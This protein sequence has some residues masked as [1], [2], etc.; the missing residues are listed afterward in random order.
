MMLEENVPDQGGKYM[1]LVNKKGVDVSSCN[2][3]YDGGSYVDFGSLK[4]NDFNFIMIRCGYGSDLVTQDD[5]CFEENVKK[6]EEAGVPWGVYLYSYAL[7]AEQAKSEAEHVKRLLKG[8]KPTLPI[9]LDVEDADGYHERNGGWNLKTINTVVKTFIN[10]IRDAGYY[11]MLYCGFEEIENL[12]SE[13]VW[14]NVDIWWAQWW[15]EC[16]YK[17]DNLGMWQ[18]GGETNYRQS[19]YID[20]KI[21]DQDLCYKDY[22]TIIKQG[23]WNNWGTPTPTPSPKKKPIEMLAFEVL[24]G[25]WGS[26][27]ERKKLLTEAGYDYQ[28]VQNRVNEIC[29]SWS[30]PTL[31]KTGYKL[32]ESNIAILA[33]KEMINFARKLGIIDQGVSDNKVYGDGTLI[34]VNLILKIGDY[35]QNGIMGE[36]FVKYL[37]KL[38]KNKMN[39]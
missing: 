34:A 14:R 19:A 22:P 32:G 30:K 5:T 15:K 38:I 2:S 4:R 24:D 6:A 23:G 3:Y 25:Y 35:N 29:A 36:N 18:Y 1:S 13:D 37:S 12:I 39:K 26:G 27:D 10:E 31:D 9:A 28:A 11:P 33:I 20:G 16:D 17:Y 7:N 21:Y 8:K